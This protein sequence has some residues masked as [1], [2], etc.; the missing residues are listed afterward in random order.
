[1]SAAEH[2]PLAVV[3]VCVRLARQARGMSQ[4]DL[5]DAMGVQQTAVSYWESGKRG[6][7]VDTFMELVG[8]LRVHPGQLL[9]DGPRPPVA[10]GGPAVAVPVAA[11]LRVASPGDDPVV[12]VYS[13]LDDAYHA[14]DAYNLAQGTVPWAQGW[15]FVQPT[16]LVHVVAPEPH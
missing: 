16:D 5:A 1:M 3:G 14:A 11:V 9:P 4:Q 15:Q 7:N 10:G 13:H 12:A 8:H 6:M 2:D